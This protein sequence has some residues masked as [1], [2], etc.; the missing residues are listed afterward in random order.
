MFSLIIVVKVYTNKKVE[1]F[2]ISL[3]YFVL[4][5]WVVKDTINLKNKREEVYGK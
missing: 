5:I 4:T 1:Y 2:G 3:E